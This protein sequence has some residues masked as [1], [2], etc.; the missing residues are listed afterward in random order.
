MQEERRVIGRGCCG[1]V[2]TT[3]SNPTIAIKVEDGS[4]DEG[5]LQR[6]C[7]INGKIQHAMN[8][9]EEWGLELEIRLPARHSFSPLASPS[10]F[11]MERIMPVSP[12]VQRETV[13][14]RYS[15]ELL[16]QILSGAD[17]Q[18]CLLRIYLGRESPKHERRLTAYTLRN[19]PLYLDTIELS[20]AEYYTTALAKT[21]AMLHWVAGVDANDV[22]FVLGA[23]RLKSK[24]TRDNNEPVIWLL[25]F[26][27][28][29]EIARDEGGVEKAVRAFFLNDPYYPRPSQQLWSLFAGTYIAES[30]L[31]FAC[32]GVESREVLQLPYSFLYG[33]ETMHA[34]RV[35]RAERGLSADSIA[36]HPSS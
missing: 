16:E 29:E 21:L 9:L 34:E 12:A 10:E 15:G 1:T 27:C 8:Q 13:S 28:C 24:I 14:K 22:E 35:Q 19:Y 2:Y 20:K 5:H 30:E 7:D 11:R 23:E 6:D 4:R 36:T 26:D 18:D 32:Q 33:V 31:L 25:D 3:T 17:A